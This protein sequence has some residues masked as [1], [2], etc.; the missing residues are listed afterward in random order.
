MECCLSANHA[1]EESD[2]CPG[3]CPNGCPDKSPEETPADT[4]TS[5]ERDCS[6]CADVCKSMS[7]A[8][9]K[10]AGEDLANSAGPVVATTTALADRCP[11]SLDALLNESQ[12][13]PRQNQPFPTSDLPLLI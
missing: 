4:D 1:G 10:M 9:E 5:N 3:G 8:P 12:R 2:G 6:T 13:Q 7:L 11:S